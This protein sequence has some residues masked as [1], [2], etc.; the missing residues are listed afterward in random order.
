MNKPV[1]PEFYIR[2]AV[3]KDIVSNSGFTAQ[4][5]GRDFGN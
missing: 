3:V 5:A 2:G 1:L 4:E